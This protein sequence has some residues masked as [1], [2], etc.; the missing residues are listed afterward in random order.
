[1]DRRE[2]GVIRMG[3]CWPLNGLGIDFSGDFALMAWYK[4]P[5]GRLKS[6][7]SI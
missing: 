1:M 2:T 5:K 4:L 6:R 7:E 3:A